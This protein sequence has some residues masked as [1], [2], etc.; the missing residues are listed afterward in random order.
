MRDTSAPLQFYFFMDGPADEQDDWLVRAT[1]KG[2]LPGIRKVRFLKPLDD[3]DFWEKI[4]QK[5]INEDWQAINIEN[6]PANVREAAEK[7]FAEF[8][9]QEDAN[10]EIYH[11]IL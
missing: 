3:G 9:P 4:N 7:R 1:F 6:V 8:D 2:N 5:K 10:R 11:P